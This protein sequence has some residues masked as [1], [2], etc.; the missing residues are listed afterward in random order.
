MILYELLDKTISIATLNAW[1]PNTNMAVVYI[2]TRI[3]AC[4]M[5]VRALGGKISMTVKNLLDTFGE[6]HDNKREEIVMWI[7]SNALKQDLHAGN[8]RQMNKGADRHPWGAQEAAPG[9]TR[10]LKEFLA[11][12]KLPGARSPRKTQQDC[13]QSIPWGSYLPRCMLLAPPGCPLAAPGSPL[14]LMT[15]FAAPL[16]LASPHSSWLLLAPPD[17]DDG[18]GM[19]SQADPFI[20]GRRP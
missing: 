4:S 13:Q 19:P 7:K 6:V 14:F 10:P 15:C 1:H 17:H 16:L 8:A 12:T 2:A 3:Q 11:P 5:S 9:P 18:N 20:D